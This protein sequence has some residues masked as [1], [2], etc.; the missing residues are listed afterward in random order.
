MLETARLAGTQVQL[1]VDAL[2]GIYAG[3]DAAQNA[4]KEASPFRCPDGCGAC[5]VDFEPDVLES[6]ALYLAVW[7]VAH[8]SERAD[9][10]LAGTWVSPRRD[11]RSG[12]FLF[13][14]ENP[15]HCTVY[16]GRGLICRL[17]GYSGDHGKDGTPRWKPCKFLPDSAELGGSLR[18]Q[19]DE[20]EL[21]A[22]FGAMPPVM[23]DIAAQVVALEPDATGE[24]KPLREALPRAIGKVLMLIRFSGDTPEPDAPEPNPESPMPLA[25]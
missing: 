3:I 16:G 9:A 17:F 24:R 15:Y 21:R 18:R 23:A 10:I 8:E 12:C 6:E 7:L 14:P 11:G 5:C 25:S 19:Y 22:I 2:D 20:D 13:D 1:V 4:W